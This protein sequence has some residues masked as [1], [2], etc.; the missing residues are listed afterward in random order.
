VNGALHA[1]LAK[2]FELDFPLNFLFVFFAPVVDAFAD[3]AGEFDEAVLG[4]G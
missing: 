4:H 3:R 1:P 2:F